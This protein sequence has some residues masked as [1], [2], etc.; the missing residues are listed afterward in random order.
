MNTID[1]HFKYSDILYTATAEFVIFKQGII[2]VYGVYPILPSHR[3][4]VYF[5]YNPEKKKMDIPFF[6]SKQKEIGKRILASICECC[7]DSAILVEMG[8]STWRK[9]KPADVLTEIFSGSVFKM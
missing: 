3:N 7:K 9:A 4:E 8:L 6:P 1:I 2:R 5:V